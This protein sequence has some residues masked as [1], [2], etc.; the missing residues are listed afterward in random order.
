[1]SKL[2]VKMFLGSKSKAGTAYA[3][4]MLLSF[5]ASI[6]FFY[7]K[8]DNCVRYEAVFFEHNLIFFWTLSY[9]RC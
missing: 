7:L 9:A 4:G 2:S 5:N 3:Y 8:P 1:M 6:T